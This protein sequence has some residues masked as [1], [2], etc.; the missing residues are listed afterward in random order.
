MNADPFRYLSD[1]ALFF[2]L[3]KQAGLS[4]DILVGAGVRERAK[5][6]HEACKVERARRAAIAAPLTIGDNHP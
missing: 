3:V 4:R 5:L 1:S 2:E 6:C